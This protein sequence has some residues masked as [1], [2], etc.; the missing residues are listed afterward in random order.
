[1][2]RKILSLYGL[3]WNPFTPDVPV[4]ALHRTQRV[5][6][7][8]FRMDNLAR[9][10]G[11]ALVSGPPGTGKSTTLRIVADHVS[12]IRDL[13]VEILTRP[14]A[15]MA[16]FYRELGDLFGVELSPHNRW[17]GT[18]VLRE[19]WKSFLETS[20]FRPM[21]LIDEAQEMAPPVLN[22]L[23]IMMS[24][25]L[26]S[27]QMLSVV[28]S[29]DHRL[30]AKLRHDEL[31]PLGSRI[32]SRLPLDAE[33]P[34]NLAACLGHAMKAA[35]NPRLMSD[36]LVTTLAEQAMGN[37]RVLM[38]MAAELLTHGAER[39]LERLDEKLYLEVFDPGPRR[40]RRGGRS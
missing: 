23:R 34:K 7:F 10:G 25:D 20:L 35:G 40:R 19:R 39:E 14:Q 5:E 27:V 33:T 18:K 8:L 26:D 16:D 15:N 4:D 21:V 28:L 3:K 2:N 22:E 12:S 11:F 1:M 31:L 32:R 13:R 6:S 36:G 24:S 29:G 38:G 37:L 30:N 9:E 17:R